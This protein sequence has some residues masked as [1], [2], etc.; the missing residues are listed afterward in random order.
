[1]RIWCRRRECNCPLIISEDTCSAEKRFLKRRVCVWMY[2]CNVSVYVCVG[3]PVRAAI[4]SASSFCAHTPI[5]EHVELCKSIRSPSW[6]DAPNV[7]SSLCVQCV[8]CKYVCK[9]ISVNVDIER[10][11]EIETEIGIQTERL[12]IYTNTLPHTQPHSYTHT[13]THTLP[14][15]QPHSYTHAHTHTHT[16]THIHTPVE[17]FWEHMHYDRAHV[18]STVAN[19]HVHCFVRVSTKI[20]WLPVL[21]VTMNTWHGWIDI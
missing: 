14:H 17:C 2:D 7:A 11:R 3:V 18:Q 4:S 19:D 15:T 16:P 10:V 13:R 20:L 5:K 9:G 1:M 12:L 8:S 21:S 6:H